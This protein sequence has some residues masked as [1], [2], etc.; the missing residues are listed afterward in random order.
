MQDA[1]TPEEVLDELEQAY[2]NA[3]SA[4]VDHALKHNLNLYINGKGSLLLE[5]DDSG[6]KGRGEWFTS[7]DSC[8]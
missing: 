2:Y 8:S 5:D 1:K 6:Y 4:L 3:E 7:T